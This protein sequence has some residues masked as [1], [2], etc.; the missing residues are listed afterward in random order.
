MIS[1]M[2]LGVTV[3]AI[4]ILSASALAQ[5]RS[6]RIGDDYARAALRAIIYT[7]QS[8]ITVQ[9]ISAFLNEA[10]VEASTPAEEASLKELNRILGEWIRHPSVD[11]QNCFLA[12]KVNLKARNGDTPEACK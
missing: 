9:R 12:L 1:K 8:G 5:S 2:K 11:R 4:F 3:I 6:S 10:D 7:A